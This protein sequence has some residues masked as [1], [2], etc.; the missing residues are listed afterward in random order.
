MIQPKRLFRWMLFISC[1]ALFFGMTTSVQAA[2]TGTLNIP[3]AY[4]NLAAAITDLNTQGVGA[5]G[6][7]LN[8]LAGNNQTAPIGGYVIGG[9]G[10]AVLTSAAAGSQITIQG[11]GNT[12]TAATGLTSGVL[13]DAIFKLVGAD[14][15]TIDNFVLRENAANLYTP[16]NPVTSTTPLTTNTMTEWGIALLYVTNTDGAQHNT[17]KNND[18]RLRYVYPNS[19]AIYSSASHTSTAPT[20]VANAAGPAGSNSFNRI[21]TNHIE[22]CTY[23]VVQVG[24]GAAASFNAMDNG[25]EVGGATAADGNTFFHV[26]GTGEVRTVFANM[27]GAAT[28][29]YVIWH[30]NQYNNVISYNTITSSM[31]PK[32]TGSAG[33]IEN[34]YVPGGAVQP[35][36]AASY[37][38][39]VEY[40]TIDITCTPASNAIAANVFGISTRAL[41]IQTAPNLA[42]YNFT[43]N[44][45]TCRILGL[46][47][48]D[49]S[50]LANNTLIGFQQAAVPEDFYGDYNVFKGFVTDAPG[51][52]ISTF[53]NFGAVSKTISMTHN[54]LGDATTPWFTNNYLTLSSANAF[55][56]ANNTG[57]PI[58]VADLSYNDIYDVV[59]NAT[60]QGNLIPLNN[61][62]FTGNAFFTHNTFHNVSVQSGGYTFC[63]NGTARA[64]GKTYEFSNNS[65]DGA[66]T[67]TNLTQIIIYNEFGAANPNTS[68]LTIKDNNFSN[69]ITTGNT[70]I[71]GLQSEGGTPPASGPQRSVS[72]NTFSNWLSASGNISVFSVSNSNTNITSIV[73]GNTVSNIHGAGIIY[74]ITSSGGNQTFTNNSVFDIVTTG[75]QVYGMAIFAGYKQFVTKNRI[76]DIT[77]G[78]DALGMLVQGVDTSVFEVSNNLIGNVNA[79]SGSS[80]AGIRT[81][82]S[83]AGFKPKLYFNTIHLEG[84]SSAANFSAYGV[85]EGTAGAILTMNNNL[86]SN[87]STPNGTGVAAAFFGSSTTFANYTT[88]SDRNDFYAPVIYSDGTNTFT[89]IA[90]YKTYIGPLRDANSIYA[91]P[92][93]VST[94]C[95]DPNFL[96]INTTFATSIESGGANIAG[97][98]DDYDAQVRQ[99]NGGYVGGGTAPDIGADEFEGTP[100]NGCAGAP[101]AGSITGVAGV[102]LGQS[103]TLSLVGSSE[104]VGITYQWASSTTPGGPYTTLLGTG[105]TQVTG[106]VNVTTYYVVTVTCTNLGGTSV[107]TSEKSVLANP[108]PTINVSPST[109]LICNP[110]GGPASLTASGASTYTWAPASGL[111]ATTGATVN[112]NPPSNRTYVV[113]GTSAA[114][115]TNTGSAQVNVSNT[116]GSPTATANP[117]VVCTGAFSELDVTA[118]LSIPST[119]N[120]YSFTTSTGTFTPLSGGT[121]VS[122]LLVDDAATVVPI[123][124][125]FQ[126]EGVSYSLAAASSNGFLSFTTLGS[127]FNNSLAASAIRAAVAPLWDDLSGVGGTASYLTSGT[128]GTR[129]FTFEWLNWRWDFSNSA[130]TIS[131]QAKLYEADGKIEFIY[132]Q[133]AA[134]PTS[135]SASIGLSGVTVGDFLSLSNS[136][137]SPSASSLVE[138]D[139]IATKPATG[140]IY[141]FTPPVATVTYAWAPA[142]GL[143]PNA[144]IQSPETPALPPGST[145]VY[146]VTITNNGCTGTATTS[147]TSGVALNCSA[148]TTSGTL[149]SGNDFQLTAN[150]TGGGAPFSYAWSD[151][152]GGVYPNAQTVTANLS[153]GTY[154]FECVVSDNCGGTCSSSVTLNIASS[155]SALISPAGPTTACT[156]SLPLVLTASTDIGTTFQWRKN[157]VDIGGAT[158]NTLNVTTSGSY[159]VLV[160]VAGACPFESAP[161]VVTVNNSEANPTSVGPNNINGCYQAVTSASFAGNCLETLVKDETGFT[162]IPVDW[163]DYD[164]TS[165]FNTSFHTL[166][167]SD[168]PAGSLITNISFSADI[169]HSYGGDL[170]MDLQ[171]PNGGPSNVIVFDPADNATVFGVLNDTTPLNYIFNSTG[172][173]IPTSGVIPSPGPYLPNTSFSSYNGFDPNG[174]WT[175][176]VRDPYQFDGG[177]IDNVIITI[178]AISPTGPVTWYNVPSGGTALATVTPFNPVSQGGANTGVASHVYDFYAECSANGCPS[179]RTHVTFTVGP[180][181]DDGDCATVDACDPATGNI[182]HTPGSCS[183]TLNSSIFIQGFYSGGGQMANAGAGTL[184]V[185][186]VSGATAT[187]SDTIR[188]AAM[189]PTS[190]YALVYEALGI[191]NTDGTVSVTFPAPVTIGNSYYLRLLH[192]NSVET[193]SAAPV[194]ISAVTS[195]PFS[196]AASQAFGSNQADLGDG[197]FA[198]FNG[199]INHDGA[200]DGSDFLEL[201]PAIQNGDGGYAVGDLNGDGAVDGSD[202]LILDPNIQNGIGAAIP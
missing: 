131:F 138:S 111:S 148:V 155:P 157:G 168:F 105:L 79:P 164:V 188:I 82:T 67:S 52:A 10:S 101:T 54:S 100:N 179:A 29:N 119:A 72:G 113:T 169:F 93:F 31:T 117:P 80:I 126:Y 170:R 186:G 190:P 34:N 9:T 102:C 143:K 152:V 43:H 70:N 165:G 59:N 47:P 202:F 51:A 172:T 19:F 37:Y 144:N 26:G 13:T 18:I 87:G 154:T 38:T 149:C 151:G 115:C 94:S 118:D 150:Y 69:I 11:N 120:T 56:I 97:I 12:I 146:T 17:I 45:V 32:T 89:N 128:T 53:S 174:T 49:N 96:H 14:Y 81:S 84:S 109:A 1:F 39:K 7:T 158:T 77:A 163:T 125:D 33:G 46:T 116:P 200:I 71:F 22:D 176:T 20:V 189:N 25:N 55:G 140:Q 175:L 181:Y 15:V 27:T 23:G 177:I 5:G 73:S 160:T 60:Y 83:V 124:F 57:N 48:T 142:A 110:G 127:A 197:N 133:E 171:A 104:D 153:A 40:N 35:N 141:R 66:F 187:Q 44:V 185:S 41:T 130:A 183:A 42:T 161:N 90:T 61:A 2:L 135:S 137:A 68:I 65:I 50:N 159:T 192:R 107:T 173:T 36:P 184:L 98:T 195:Y 194:T 114:G 132:R 166:I 147:V 136:S 95:G 112:A 145:T 4:P 193:W 191:I 21:L 85:I 199:D 58:A 178:T 16:A 182:T 122:T 121:A 86:I 201:D 8:L 88:T 167:V 139:N 63:Q 30:N 62:G 75:S 24:S 123:G 103:T 76:C 196:T 99:G 78:D 64:A 108:I 106:P 162:D 92:Q 3:G 91:R 6:V 28:T 198:I 129:V 134:V 156:P 180:N 74:G